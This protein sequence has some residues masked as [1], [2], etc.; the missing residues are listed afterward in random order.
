MKISFNLILRGL[1]I[2]C[3]IAAL[4][5]TI[6]VERF[7]SR[8]YTS[9]ENLNFPSGQKVNVVK[10]IDGDEIAVKMN[11]SQFVVRILGISSYEPAV[12]DPVMENV[13]KDTLRYLEK[14]ILNY[15]VELVFEKFQQD[16]DKR[17]LA[18]VY[19][20]GTDVGLSMVEN[21]L[22]IV[23]TRYPFPRIEEYLH[24]ERISRNARKGLWAVPAAA[25]RSMML[26]KLWK[27]GKD[28]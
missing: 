19:Y 21:G 25:E 16:K 22:S 28:N 20:K 27:K 9:A 24:S 26:K 14:T 10:I 4:Y 8:L 2:F 13:A 7:K 12:N 5:F 11:N 23:Y 18:Y 17:V 3:L 15:D 6:S 1:F